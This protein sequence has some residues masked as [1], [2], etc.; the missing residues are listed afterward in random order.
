[1]LLFETWGL[2]DRIVGRVTTGAMST[3]HLVGGEKGG[4]GKSVMA[5]VLAQ[6]FIDREVKF[7]GMDADTSHGALLRYYGAYSHP[8]DLSSFD[9]ADQIMDRA[10]GAE[11]RVLVDLP[12]QSSRLLREWLDA[13]DVVSFARDMNVPLVYWHVSDGGFDSV[14]QLQAAAQ[15]LGADVQFV[16]VKNFGRSPDFGQLDDAPA[17]TALLERG[18]R[19]VELPA[20]DPKA[21]YQIDRFGLSFWAAIHNT[22]GE[23]ALSP[24]SRRRVHRWYGET[25]KALGC[26]EDL[27]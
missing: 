16:V 11:R 3:L 21:M 19:V 14:G 1:M 22:E 6:L 18:A 4:V 5:R 13:G 7:A 24:M 17:F 12:A 10:I 23:W 9:S 15:T 27:I 25:V 2:L 8:T 26:V 20:L